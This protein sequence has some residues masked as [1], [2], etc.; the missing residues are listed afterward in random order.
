[1]ISRRVLLVLVMAACVLPV[2]IT[3]VVAVGR[4]LGAMNDAAGASAL[5]G[6]ALALGIAW[7]VGLVCLVVALAINSLGPPD[8]PA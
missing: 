2:A 4:L 7:I 3:V 1:M 5:D 8:G 6:V